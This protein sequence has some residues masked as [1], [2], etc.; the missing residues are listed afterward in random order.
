MFWNIR[1][2]VCL[3]FLLGN[4][5]LRIAYRVHTILTAL[6]ELHSCDEFSTNT[7]DTLILICF[8]SIQFLTRDII[9]QELLD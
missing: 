1:F 4:E 3:F 5:T 7:T 8:T 6:S 2:W 9:S